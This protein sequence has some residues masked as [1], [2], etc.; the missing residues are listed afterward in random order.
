MNKEP[1]HPL[2]YKIPCPECGSKTLSDGTVFRCEN[3]ECDLSREWYK[4][5]PKFS[6]Y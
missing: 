4:V 3:L 6:V 1:D 2:D 5:R